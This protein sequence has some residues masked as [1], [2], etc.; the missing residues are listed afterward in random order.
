[1]SVIRVTAAP[2]GRALSAVVG[3]LRLRAGEVE[4]LTWDAPPGGESGSATL[5]ISLGTARQAH[6]CAALRRL[7]DV[8]DVQV[9]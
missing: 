3:L 4:S 6:V 9:M 1:M 8:I 2:T 5:L 7:V